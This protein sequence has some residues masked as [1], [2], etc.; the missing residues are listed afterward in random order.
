MPN[1]S[2]LEMV[3]LNQ[4]ERIGAAWNYRSRS[5]LEGCNGLNMASNEYLL[6]RSQ[7]IKRPLEEVFAFFRQPENL[8]RITPPWLHFK[9]TTPT[10]IP[11]RAGLKIDYTVRPLLVP[12][13]WTSLIE[14]YDPPHMFIDSQIRGPY[15]KWH[16]T[17]M[18]REGG[19]GTWVEDRVVYALPFGI[20][21]R[22]AHELKVKHQLND[23]F[24]YRTKVIGDIFR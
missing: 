21:G 8:S 2:H 19:G 18:F 16:H 22:I 17:H 6:N 5:Q 3:S 23:I 4:D 20:L 12:M 9:I 24:N 1:Q 7:F 11:M 10:P 14:A 15:K 13:K